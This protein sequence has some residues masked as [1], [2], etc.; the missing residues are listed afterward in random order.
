MRRLFLTIIA[1]LMAF[2]YSWAGDY[3]RYYQNL[4][5]KVTPVTTF[6]LPE[7]QVSLT[8]FGGIGDGV[9]LNTEAF[10]KAISALQKKG[11]GR[12]IVPD[13]V[14]LTGPILLKDSIDLHL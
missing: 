3:E 14:W 11:G 7:N 9:T 8:D 4:P 5:T 13:G 12:L 2:G 6:S 10:R 1:T